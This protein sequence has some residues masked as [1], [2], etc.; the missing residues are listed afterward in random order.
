MLIFFSHLTASSQD[1]PFI[2]ENITPFSANHFQTNLTRNG[3]LFFEGLSV[4]NPV[5]SSLNIAFIGGLWI[6]GLYPDG[7][8]GLAATQYGIYSE[9]VDFFPGPIDNITG[10][11]V[12]NYCEDYDKSWIVNKAEI[13]AH[14][15]DY[16]DNFIIDNPIENIF[17]WPAYRNDF[18]ETYNGFE[19]PAENTEWASFFDKNNNGA[20]EP[21]LGEYPIAPDDSF[22]IPQTIA[23]TVINDLADEHTEA[24]HGDPLHIEVQYSLWTYQCNNNPLLENTL[25]TELKI[26]NKSEQKLDSVFVGLFMD[27]DI[28]CPDDDFIGCITNQNSFFAYTE[29]DFDGGEAFWINCT[30]I[31]NFGTKPP[32]VSVTML[33]NSLDVFNSF[34]KSQGSLI[35]ELVSPGNAGEYYNL[36]TGRFRGGR[37]I[38][39]DFEYGYDQFEEGGFDTTLYLFPG[40]PNISEEWSMPYSGSIHSRPIGI[41]KIGQLAQKEISTLNTALSL[42]QDSTIEN[43]QQY[44]LMKDNIEAIQNLYDSNFVTIPCNAPTLRG[45]T[46]E[47]ITIYPNPNSEGILQIDFKETMVLPNIKLYHINGQFLYEWKNWT[48]NSEIQLPD[49]IDGIYI[50]DIKTTTNSVVHKLLI[51]NL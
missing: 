40:D 23:W 48:T 51:R 12:E 2:Y 46:P 49:L 36:L 34:Y 50:L 1:C 29:D 42:H 19:L 27:F 32:M 33:N 31:P 22:L 20:Y 9:Q 41:H 8:L 7:Q 24:K 43:H 14:I 3:T 45:E 18:F 13:L 38:V 25:F 39:N 4:N 44:Y 28:G 30:D 16:N 26:F 47:A 35:P 11:V 6:G 5:D 15:E 37:P 10:Q 17:A 21:D